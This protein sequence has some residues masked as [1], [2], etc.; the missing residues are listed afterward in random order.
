MNVTLRI[1]SRRGAHTLTLVARP[2]VAATLGEYTL[3][4]GVEMP[5]DGRP[6]DT[7]LALLRQSYLMI[8]GR[9]LE[10]GGTIS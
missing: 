6:D 8:A 10:L 9:V 4:E 5:E 2:H 3:F 1:E 7:A